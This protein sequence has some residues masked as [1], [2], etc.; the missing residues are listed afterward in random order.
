MKG[1]T[2]SILLLAA[3]LALA[4][5]LARAQAEP[6]EPVGTEEPEINWVDTSHEYATNQA[7]ALTRWMDDFFG[8]PEYNLEQAESWLRVE[9]EDDWDQEDGHDFGVRLRGKVHLPK[10]SRRVALVFNGEESELDDREDRDLDD[11]VGLQLNVSEGKRNRWDATL[12]VGSGH[13]KPGIKFRSEGPLNEQTSY[14]Y[15][16]RAQYEDG[17]GFFTIPN[18]DINHILDENRIVRWNNRL[19]WGERTEGVEWRTRLSMRHR[20]EDRRLK[21]PLAMNY[22]FSVSG[23][24]RPESFVK[25]YRL[26]FL[27]RRRIYRDFLFMELEPAYNWRRRLYEDEREGVWSMAVR[28]EIALEQNL[29][30]SRRREG[31]E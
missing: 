3:H 19:L 23:V 18:L 22:F 8:D 11:Q 1:K 25:N 15:V 6:G 26:G 17:E 13:L 30:R 14:R 27:W 20:F 31:N 5:S 29:K 9:F 24:T 10:T 16:Q 12:S 21:Y 4:S 2:L 28:F 7:Q